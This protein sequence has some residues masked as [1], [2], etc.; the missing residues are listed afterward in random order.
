[1]TRDE[2]RETISMSIG[3]K[4][5]AIVLAAG[6][7]TRMRSDKAKVL[8][9]IGGLSMLGHVL[10][11]LNGA[12]IE[13]VA[14]VIGHNGDTVRAD[15]Q[16][17]APAVAVFEQTEQLGTA[18]AVLSARQAIEAFDG[19]HVLVLYGDTPL[20]RTD[21]LMALL[22]GIDAG[23]DV[24]VT[25]FEAEVPGRY[26]RLI[27]DEDQLIAIREAKDA[28]PDELAITFC[29]GGLK[30]FRHSQ[31]LALL[32]AIDDNNAQ[33]EF[34]LTDAVEIANARGLQVS[35]V[36]IAETEVL[37]VNDRV[38]LAEAT[39]L[40]QNRA[41]LNAMQNGVTLEAPESVVFSH[42]TELSSD[43]VV[44]PN[45]VFG[46]G[47]SV[48]S[49]V[50]IRAFSHLEGARVETGAV[51]GPY[52]R[53][54]PGTHVNTGAKIGNFVETKKAVIERG[55][56][57]NHLSYIGD[58]SIGASANIG[59]G[60]I[61]CNYDG[62]SKFQTDIGAGAFIGSNSA[63]VAPVTIGE[64]A[65]VGSGSVITDDVPDHAL[66]LGRGRQVVKPRWAGAFKA[67]RKN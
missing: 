34:Y 62:Q 25:G 65:F 61:T 63:L 19:D 15:L 59:A 35:A 47:V 16:K 45:V 17:Q 23:S 60:T 29:N 64:G 43:V 50:Q 8:H 53:L 18:H 20:V 51:I 42:D 58:A 66:A 55:A 24:V 36:K 1:M 40:F 4:T 37:G 26:G 11:T 52:A 7:G 22:D 38:Q 46:L 31:C 28:T 67:K 3:R 48:A 33:N 6:Q 32:D 12:D 30:A 21:T 57:V 54:R 27:M 49:G 56:K 14:V 9:E 5:L 2:S 13:D 10:K 44:E 41:R 39:R